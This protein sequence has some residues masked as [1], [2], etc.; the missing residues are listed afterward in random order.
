[1]IAAA[2]GCGSRPRVPSTARLPVQRPR[3]G[4]SQS[5]HQ[6]HNDA[7]PLK[8]EVVR[9][10]GE[11]DLDT[12]TKSSGQKVAHI[13]SARTLTERY[14]FHPAIPSFSWVRGQGWAGGVESVLCLG[15]SGSLSPAGSPPKLM[16]F[17]PR[18]G[19]E[20][21][22]LFSTAP[23]RGAVPEKFLPFYDPQN[24]ILLAAFMH[25]HGCTAN[26]STATLE[27]RMG[28]LEPITSWTRTKV[29]QKYAHVKLRETATL[30]FS[31]L[32]SPPLFLRSRAT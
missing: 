27:S 14:D 28:Q 8:N 7:A 6:P 13:A 15:R 16:I 25:S 5:C 4:T 2:A 11:G 29:H 9:E 26:T 24:A 18:T 23:S 32:E 1:M 12:P 30:D 20:L 22:A 31:T 21:P 17:R 19:A 3:S 10:G